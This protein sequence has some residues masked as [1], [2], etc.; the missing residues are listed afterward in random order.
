[1]NLM[2]LN[3]MKKELQDRKLELAI[4]LCQEDRKACYL[5][6]EYRNSVPSE[7]DVPERI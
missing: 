5:I 4:K 7:T 2:S 6:D 3:N 1:M